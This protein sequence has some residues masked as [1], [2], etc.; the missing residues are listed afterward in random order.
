MAVDKRW[1]EGLHGL[2][3]NGTRMFYVTAIVTT[4]ASKLCS[5]PCA[6]SCVLFS[7]ITAWKRQ[8]TATCPVLEVP[9]GDLGS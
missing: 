6:P 5:R 4:Y 3:M 8:Q 9:L 7:I 1:V 2:L